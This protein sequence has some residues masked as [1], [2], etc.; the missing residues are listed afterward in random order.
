[1]NRPNWS[2]LAPWAGLICGMF[3]AGAQHQLL[4]DAVRFDCGFNRYGLLVALGAWA[5]TG[6]GA[7]ISWRALR[8]HQA[9]DS[10]RRFVSQMSLMA[11]AL[12]ALMVGWQ[13]MASVMLPGC[14]P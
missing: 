12:F 14:T 3:S 1:M 2:E 10:A 6:L 9:P 8:A 7:L 5:L 11:T 4:S 13:A